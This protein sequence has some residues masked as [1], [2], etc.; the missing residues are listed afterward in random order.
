M[1]CCVLSF[2]QFTYAQ[3]CSTVTVEAFPM[4]PQSGQYN[5][6]GVR[7]TLAQA[8]TQD[9]T[10]TGYIHKDADEWNNQDHPFHLVLFLNFP[11]VKVNQ[12]YYQ[13]SFKTMCR[14]E[15]IF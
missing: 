3:E 4:D 13:P 7:V 10:V 14:K 2:V 6:F 11:K 5:Y 8:Y 15:T 12:Y 1:A 9:V